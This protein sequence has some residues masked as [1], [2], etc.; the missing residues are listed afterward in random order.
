MHIQS[1]LHIIELATFLLS[2]NYYYILSYFY[3][4]N[5]EELNHSPLPKQS[6]T[7]YILS[8]ECMHDINVQC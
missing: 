5:G 1:L 4:D 3:L 8:I 7:I 2:N 6:K